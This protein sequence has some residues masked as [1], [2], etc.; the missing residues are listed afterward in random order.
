[1]IY[2][3]LEDVKEKLTSLLTPEFIKKEI[4]KAEVLAIFKSEAKTVIIGVKVL[5]GKVTKDLK[6]NVY[7][8]KELVVSGEITEVQI[9]KEKVTDAVEGQEC[10]LRFM[11]KPEVK[12]GDVLELFKE[13]E[14]LK[15]L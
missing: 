1:V 2:K 14:I 4:G 6:A 8:K 5:Q 3:L 7:R 12:I 15:K 11:G 13:E 10:G 9:G